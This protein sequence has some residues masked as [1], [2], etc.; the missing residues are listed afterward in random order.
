MLKWVIY[1]KHLKSEISENKTFYN[2]YYVKK[3]KQLFILYMEIPFK[4]PEN[5]A[6][7]VN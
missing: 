4:T 7:T 3:I 6:T 1:L 5:K 2:V